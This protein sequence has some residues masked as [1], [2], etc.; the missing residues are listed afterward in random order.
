M[1]SIKWAQELGSPI[2]GHADGPNTK[3]GRQVAQGRQDEDIPPEAFDA[4]IGVED[5]VVAPAKVGLQHRT[6]RILGVFGL[7]DACHLAAD[8]RNARREALAVRPHIRVDAK[9]QRLAQNL[10]PCNCG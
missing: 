4:L 7:D 1:N 2:P 6:H 9:E 5:G 10:C 3:R 8:H